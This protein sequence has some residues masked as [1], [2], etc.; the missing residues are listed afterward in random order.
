MKKQE[1]ASAKDL[2]KTEITDP[3]D[4]KFKWPSG[5]VLVALWT[6]MQTLIGKTSA[7]EN[8]PSDTTENVKAQIED[9]EESTLSLVLHLRGGIINPSLFQLTQK[10]NCN[11]MICFQCYAYL[12]PCAVNCRKKCGHTNKLHPKR[13]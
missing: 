11:K 9:K 4:K 10:S 1:K 12:Q 5:S 6:E 13:R 3:P 2:D 8:E 7:L